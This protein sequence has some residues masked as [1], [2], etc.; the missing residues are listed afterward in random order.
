MFDV[1]T[2]AVLGRLRQLNIKAN[3][4]VELIFYTE[5][6]E[7]SLVFLFFFCKDALQTQNTLKTRM[8]QVCVERTLILMFLTYGKGTDHRF[9]ECSISRCL[10]P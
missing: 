6:S 5:L 1:V 2:V 8:A 3:L 9:C 4:N 7:H 10:K